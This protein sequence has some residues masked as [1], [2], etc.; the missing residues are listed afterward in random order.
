MP[1][2]GWQSWVQLDVPPP[3]GMEHLTKLLETAAENIAMMPTGILLDVSEWLCDRAE[4]AIEGSEP[5]DASTL[6]RRRRAAGRVTT[7][8]A[9]RGEGK[10]RWR[11]GGGAKFKR[12]QR[13]VIG[14]VNTGSMENFGGP[15]GGLARALT[16]QLDV[17]AAQERNNIT[18]T[19]GLRS[20]DTDALREIGGGMLWWGTKGFVDYADAHV[21]K[22]RNNHP[23]PRLAALNFETNDG[24][25]AEL[26]D[27]MQEA[28]SS[29][30]A[31]SLEH[32]GAPSA[33]IQAV[34]G[35]RA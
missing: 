28:V 1:V 7:R 33:W 21:F 5:P 20:N 24:N 23:P 34:T 22:T 16:H 6:A 35:D 31:A 8:R 26:L 30:L 9:K 12:G 10:G 11:Q 13:G 15:T 2:L 17:R 19:H 32:A 29:S 18:Q 25:K 14:A 27:F 3:E 4:E